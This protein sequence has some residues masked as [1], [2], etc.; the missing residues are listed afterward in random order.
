[1]YMYFVA[2]LNKVI[3]GID[4]VY[5]CKNAVKC[6][7]IVLPVNMP[8]SDSTGTVLVRCWQHR[9]STGPLWH[10]YRAVAV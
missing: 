3:R 9:P 10:V 1:M 6:V 2:T 5:K 8:V 7:Y 4:S